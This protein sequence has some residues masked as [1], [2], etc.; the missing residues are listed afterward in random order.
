M[1]TVIKCNGGNAYKVGCVSALTKPSALGVD[2]IKNTLEF[3][4]LLRTASFILE[5]T[6]CPFK[7]HYLKG[8][9]KLKLIAGKIEIL[10]V[11]NHNSSY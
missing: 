4:I 6:L 8:H 5:N 11:F 7:Y 1:N 3:L 9:V 2:Y 10:Y